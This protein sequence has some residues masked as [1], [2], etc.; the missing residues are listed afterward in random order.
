MTAAVRDRGKSTQLQLAWQ[1]RILGRGLGRTRR[2]CLTPLVH[3]VLVSALLAACGGTAPGEGHPVDVGLTPLESLGTAS[4]EPCRSAGRSAEHWPGERLILDRASGFP[5]LLVAMPTEVE[6]RSPD[7]DVVPTPSRQVVRL[8]SGRFVT[9]AQPTTLGQVLLWDPDGSFVGSYGSRGSGPGEFAGGGDLA[10]IPGPGDTLHVLD[11]LNTWSVLD[12][13]LSFVRSFRGL[14]SGRLR[15][16]VHVT[17]TGEILT[18]GAVLSGGEPGAMHLMDREGMPLG[19]F[20]PAPGSPGSS[21]PYP[22]PRQGAYDPRS[23]TVWVAPEDG[24]PG[25]LTLEEWTLDGELRRVLVR[26]APWFPAE[27]YPPSGD[28]TEPP[29]PTWALVHLDHE[30]L[31]WVV[32]TIRSEA[33]RPPGP[34]TPAVQGAVRDTLRIRT[35]YEVRLEVID[36]SAGDVVASAVI[37]DPLAPPFEYLFPGSRTAYRVATD[38]L[39]FHTIEVFDVEVLA[40]P[41]G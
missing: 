13:E 39:G 7:R 17:A 19:H 3:M 10:L 28:P 12:S 5:C 18:T 24:A 9:T 30:G 31:L 22:L 32:A 25:P 2:L 36:P 33:W 6:I 40:R 34:A 8:G 27:G 14:Y 1:S 38:P 15:G 26:E 29:L 23:N 20:G 41:G 16:S 21:V 35:D 11:D 4:V 37:E